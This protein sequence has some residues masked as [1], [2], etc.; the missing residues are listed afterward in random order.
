MLSRNKF[1]KLSD[2]TKFNQIAKK[3]DELRYCLLNKSSDNNLLEQIKTLNSFLD[4]DLSWLK[5]ELALICKP[6]ITTRERLEKTH[7]LF[8]K[9]KSEIGYPVSESQFLQIKNDNT[10]NINVT[11]T[12]L[13]II[14]ENLRS[15][16]NVGSFFRMA[17]CF[18]VKKII[19]TGLTPGIENRS[20]LKTSKGC[21]KFITV[22]KVEDFVSVIEEFKEC[23][24]IINGCETATNSNNLYNFS[25]P[26]KSVLIFGNEE[27][28]ITQ[29]VLDICDNIVEIPLMGKKNSLNVATAASA[30]I[31]EYNRQ[32]II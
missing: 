26:N 28:G 4:D 15:A 13:V 1:K 9:L 20:V 2:K 6:N 22:E 11:K 29:K 24:Y 30:I 10:N 17:D 12:E 8:H 23:G 27:I 5:K 19:I 21:E 18:G 31:S 7:F 3:L 32:L 16:F 14:L 25:F